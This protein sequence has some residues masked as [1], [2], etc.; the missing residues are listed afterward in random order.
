V[1]YTIRTLLIYLL[2]LCA[3][4]SQ[5]ITKRE[6]SNAISEEIETKVIE[7]RRFFHQ[8]PELSNREYKTGIR[9]AGELRRM[10]M[11]VQTRVGNTGVVGILKGDLPGPVVA[12]RADIDALPVTE[13]GDLPFASKMV[14]ENNGIKTGVMHACGH[15]GHIAIA[16]GTAEVLSKMKSELKG[17]VKFIFQPAEEGVPIGEEGGA[18]MMVKEGV[19][20]NPDVDA[21]FGL[22]VMAGLKTGQIGYRSAGIMASSDRFIIK[23]KGKQTHGSTPWG[24]IDPI[25]TAAQIINNLQTIVSR[26]TPLTDNIAVVSVGMI[27]AGNRYNIIPEE[28]EIVG[29][30]RTLDPQL[31]KEI[32]DRIKLI[33]TNTAESNGATAEISI[34]N[35]APVTYNDPTLTTMMIPTL[36]KVVGKENANINN[37]TTAAEDFSFFQQKVPGMYFF[38]GVSTTGEDKNSGFAGHH[39]PDFKMNEDALIIGV[40]A[41]TNLTL[42]YMDAPLK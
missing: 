12:I 4:F 34:E 29:T 20:E 17:T 37:P 10:G 13:R 28:V 38:L 23:I 30:V 25:V 15:D 41:L 9:I 24:G 39:S 36:E 16:L 1:N 8:N 21:I 14:S 35:L 26:Y 22:H 19:L 31:Q 2:L 40:R 6:N 3:L 33:A 11:E 5:E 18:K 27:K 42:D 7:W 32:H